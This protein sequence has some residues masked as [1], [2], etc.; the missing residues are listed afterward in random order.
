MGTV[1]EL[2]TT[3]DSFGLHGVITI[4]FACG[5]MM[6]A[7]QRSDRFGDQTFLLISQ[8]EELRTRIRALF[9]LIAAQLPPALFNN[10]T[11]SQQHNTLQP[12]QLNMIASAFVKA[13]IHEPHFFLALAQH[14]LHQNWAGRWDGRSISNM[15]W[16]FAKGGYFPPPE[17]FPPRAPAAHANA[18]ADFEL[19][20][21]LFL[22]VARRVLDSSSSLLTSFNNQELVNV[23][24]AFATAKM[25]ESPRGN[26]NLFR[27][28]WE[29]AAAE[30]GRR[31]DLVE[32]QD[33][34]NTMS[35]FARLTEHYQGDREAKYTTNPVLP[36]VQEL[37]AGVLLRPLL[38]ISRGTLTSLQHF[39][40]QNI[41]N[42]V[43]AVEKSG[44]ASPFAAQNL[45]ERGLHFEPN[46]F[47]RGV[48]EELE[49]RGRQELSR[50]SVDMLTASFQRASKCCPAAKT[51][52][53]DVLLQWTG[54]DVD[55]FF[56]DG[57]TSHETE[58][59]EK[60]TL[61]ARELWALADPGGTRFCE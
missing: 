38:P 17:V 48:A 23:L 16:S 50:A 36:M 39:P 59:A 22:G 2:I 31:D 19:F 51:F 3:D 44:L 61:I 27:Q 45:K 54:E 24:W 29:R 46:K 40:Q 57:G 55:A 1:H 34:A 41:A 25:F 35:S 6:E 4:L 13:N 43:W 58:A 56:R 20:R 30:L 5:R 53:T 8:E 60:A 26:M 47:F 18:P 42:I 12:Q 33:L 14:L 7:L 52:L 9:S 28:F 10:S 21:K 37:F 49:R 15:L 32:P 11:T